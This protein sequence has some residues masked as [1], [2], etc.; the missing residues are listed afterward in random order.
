MNSTIASHIRS[1]QTAFIRRM[2]SCRQ[3]Q[4]TRCIISEPWHMLSLTLQ[5]A[6]MGNH[7]QYLVVVYEVPEKLVLVTPGKTGIG[8][9]FYSSVAPVSRPSKYRCKEIGLVTPH[10]VASISTSCLLTYFSLRRT[11][12]PRISIEVARARV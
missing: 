12:C 10:V 1:Q 4:T 3:E 5:C 9:G 2:P 6:R 8:H 11:C 7:C